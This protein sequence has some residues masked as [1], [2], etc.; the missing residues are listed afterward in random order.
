M[1]TTLSGARP[2][3]GCRLLRALGGL[4]IAAVLLT[5]G[6]TA[7]ADHATRDGLYSDT[8]YISVQF[9]Y[10][11]QWEEPWEADPDS[12]ESVEG[13]YDRV[14]VSGPDAAVEVVLAYGDDPEA[15]LE[16]T[17]DARAE[18]VDNLEVVGWGEAVDEFDDL[19]VLTATL[20]YEVTD[21][22]GDEVQ[23]VEYV[24][25]GYLYANDGSGDSGTRTLSLVAPVDEL[26]DTY[27]EIQ[28][29]FVTYSGF[30]GDFFAGEPAF[31]EDDDDRD[32]GDD[33][34]DEDEDDDRD[35][36]EDDEDEREVDTG[37]D[38][39]AYQSPTYGYT[40]EWDPDVWEAT[41]A[42][43]ED[44]GDT[45][46][47]TSRRSN[48]YF[49]A[50]TGYYPDPNDCLEDMADFMSTDEGVDDWEPLEDGDGEPVAGKR[51]GRAWAAFT[52][53]YTTEDGDEYENANYIECRT[54]DEGE[55]TLVIIHITS[56]DAYE[57]EAEAVAE[58]LDTI[59]LA[60]DEDDRD[61]RGR[62]GSDRDRDRDED[63]D[64]DDR[65]EADAARET[66]VNPTWGYTVTWDPEVWMIFS[67]PTE[68]DGGDFLSLTMI[69]SNDFFPM[70]AVAGFAGYDGD[71]EACLA[72]AVADAD[73]DN[74]NPLVSVDGGNL[75]AT[76]PGVVAGL[77]EN[78]DLAF[79]FY[80][81]CRTLV[82]GEAVVVITFGAS[83]SDYDEALPAFEE[84]LTD[85][86]MPEE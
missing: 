72:G 73:E 15:V 84:I 31:E 62:N 83:A 70:V 38:G 6:Q 26:E 7:R 11:F 10:D 79:Y 35:A 36:A 55:A 71:P 2:A 3:G 18:E 28:D 82:P 42:D 57:D 77:Y 65:A 52:L 5:S 27:E 16:A 64:E 41:T 63:E 13:E 23:Q 4:L 68:D 85:F 60:D 45:L 30:G 24:E 20:T 29:I 58:V 32:R 74:E 12:V 17:I 78:T 59:E 9:W 1:G 54:L 80:Y 76:A 25:V 34:A 14:V 40:L 22:D 75:P 53:T 49:W 44:E 67:G 46:V 48:L 50:G 56:Q 43:S 47:L 19:P 8:Q 86:Q 33:D 61:S 81:E 39:D 66:Y 69:G 37:L 21:A 51:R